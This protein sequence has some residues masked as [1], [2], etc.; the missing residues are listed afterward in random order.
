M[1][2]AL[3]LAPVVLLI[4]WAGGWWVTGLIALAVVI[5][6]RE[7]VRMLRAGNLHP[8]PLVASAIGLAFIGAVVLQSRTSINLV[9][10][11]LALG[12]IGAFLAEIGRRDRTGS[13]DAWAVSVAGALYVG[14]LLMH[15]ILLRELNQPALSAGPLDALKIAPGAGWIYATFAVTWAAD[16]GA[17][18]AGRAFGRHKLSP[19]LSPKKTW[20][21]FAGG[22]LAAIGAGVGIIALLGLPVSPLVG[23]ALGAIGAVGGTLG[24]LAE[25]LL[26]RQAGVKD[27]GA[28][29]PGHGGLLDRIDS[30][31]FTGPLVYYLLVVIL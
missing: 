6:I 25:S 16:S 15:F 26:K 24:D 3:V 9:A 20:E 19:Q 18:F 29:I 11:V 13:L 4:V 23:V 8:R 27:S 7:L 28:L 17:Y 31:L 10:E 30:L 21:G 14:G 1:I 2:S 5:G 12:V 22:L